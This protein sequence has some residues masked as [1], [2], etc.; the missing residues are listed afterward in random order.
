M[1]VFQSSEGD[2]IWYVL[3]CCLPVWNLKLKVL[4]DKIVD[5]RLG[6][7]KKKKKKLREK[8]WLSE[9]LG[10]KTI[11]QPRFPAS[12]ILPLLSHPFNNHVKVMEFED[13]RHLSGISGYFTVWSKEQLLLRC[14]MSGNEIQSLRTHPCR[15]RAWISV[16]EDLDGDLG[17]CARSATDDLPK[18]SVVP[19]TPYSPSPG[20]QTL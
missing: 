10:T 12:D 19:E 1:C 17:A 3:L 2:V 8:Q 16:Q 20:F 14:E 13:F 9:K 15:A 18:V 4:E 6:K 5:Y 7:K 11:I